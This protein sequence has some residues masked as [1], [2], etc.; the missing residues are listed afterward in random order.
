MTAHPVQGPRS[1]V[2]SAILWTRCETHSSTRFQW[3]AENIKASFVWYADKDKLT[4]TESTDWWVKVKK[5]ASAL[6]SCCNF[7]WK[8]N[9][10]IITDW[11]YNARLS[12][13][14]ISSCNIGSC[15]GQE[16]SISRLSRF[17]AFKEKPGCSTSPWNVWFILHFIHR[18]HIPGL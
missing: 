16:V 10:H 18:C 9:P 5:S 7:Y 12:S 2:L 6:L 15:E 1:T 13:H 11:G 4:K 14:Q 17:I 8:K 3:W